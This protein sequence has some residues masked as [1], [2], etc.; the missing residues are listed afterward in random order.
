M[1]KPQRKGVPKKTNE[2]HNIRLRELRRERECLRGAT[3]NQVPP[4]YFTPSLKEICAKTIADHFELL[5]NVD[6]LRELE[7]DLYILVLDQLPTDLKLQVAVPRV[8]AQDYWRACCE[9]RWSVGQLTSYTKTGK[10]EP[11]RGGWKRIYLER[12]LEEHLMSLDAH[13]M[14]EEEENKLAQLCA[15]CGADIYSLKLTH[16]RCHFDIAESLFAK[17]PHL[18]ELLLTFTVLN[19]A[20]T[21]KLDMIGMKQQDALYLQRVLKTC[22]A[23]KSLSL[24]GNRIDADL[25]KA[26]LAGLVKNNTLTYLDLSH[27][28]IDDNGAAAIGTILLKKDLAIRH[29]D[30]G[31]NCIRAEGAKHIG[32][33]LGANEV[34]QFLSL[35]LNRLGDQGGSWLLEKLSG[36]NSVVDINIANNQLGAETAKVLSE[37]LKTNRSLLNLDISGNEFREEGGKMLLEGVQQCSSLRQI[38]IRNCGVGEQELNAMNVLVQKR[39][40]AF[41]VNDVEKN[42]MQMRDDITRLVAEKVRKT[43]GV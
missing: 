28:K 4:A 34:I 25:L 35:R 10:L 29:L 38:D 31:D 21:F 5:P 24:P 22:P 16:Q 19:A 40:Q 11:D 18:E 1:N 33:A 8:K 7:E 15:L 27:N 6:S 9:A 12:N 41:K 14:T 42:E 23:L 30:L 13:Q 17:L 3:G 26:I 2:F 43:H 20:V 32:R 36:N 39:V 37:V